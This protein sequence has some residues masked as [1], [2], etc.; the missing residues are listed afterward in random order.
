MK[1]KT[2]NKSKKTVFTLAAVTGMSLAAVFGAVKL[3][4]SFFPR[5]ERPDYSTYPG[6]YNYEIAKQWVSREEF[7][8]P[9]GSVNL[10]GYYYPAEESKGMVVV[11]HG[12]HS[13][14]DDYLPIIIYL[15]QNHYS[16]FAYDGH[17]TYDSEGSSTVGMCQP[18]VDI[19]YT[20]S[21]IQKSQRF[22]TQP[23]FLLG[24][25]CGG[26]AVTSILKLKKG[27]K[28]C[29]AIAPV[30]NGYTLIL[31]KGQQYAGALATMGFSKAFLDT[32]QKALFGE[33]VEYNG[34]KGVNSTTIP[35]LIAHGTEDKVISYTEQSVISYRD[36]ITNPNVRYYVKSGYQGGHNSIWH[37]E[38]SVIYKEKIKQELKE[39]KKE[40]G[41]EITHE[42]LVSFYKKVDNQ[43]YSEI[44][45]ELMNQIIEMFD[46]AK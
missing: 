2:N 15:V 9:A 8:F 13:G 20:I 17:G 35:V 6:V 45:Y 39:W 32:Y 11:V 43:L 14:A 10:K 24:H 41:S 3:Y 34:V 27:I 25:S 22:Q 29:A 23:L 38:E 16:V 19:D 31:Q 26:Y 44:N 12:L 46:S 4:N 30:N 28:A 5:Y 7:Y 37:S 18:L 40:K 42:E 1:E 21:Y 36:Y 33:Y